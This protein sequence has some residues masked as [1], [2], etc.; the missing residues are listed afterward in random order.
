M[1]V[2]AISDNHG[3]FN[4]PIDDCDI[5]LICGDITP[6]DIQSNINL[7]LSWFET[8]FI[9]WA[10]AQPCEKV[11]FIG[12]NHDLFLAEA[13]SMAKDMLLGNDKIVYLECDV[14]EFKGIRIYGTPLCKKFGRWSFMSSTSEQN[15]VYQKYLDFKDKT[16]DHIDI[17]MSHDTPYGVSDVILEDCPWATKDHIGNKA[18]AK[19]VSAVGPKYLFHGHI[20]SSSHEVEMLGDTEVYNVSLLGED[21]KMKYK[22]LYK[23]I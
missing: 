8:F 22:P 10:N 9:P 1:K 15:E 23:N 20:H 12:G 7:S 5:L 13:S 21:Y 19:F 18:L 2:C 6:L 11:V 3:Q 14:F 16:N 17:I 4:V